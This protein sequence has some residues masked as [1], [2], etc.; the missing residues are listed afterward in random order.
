[1]NRSD[2]TLVA[3]RKTD[4]DWLGCRQTLVPGANGSAW[5]AAFE[6][7][8][9]PRLALRYLDP[10]KVLQDNGKFQGE[11]FSIAAIQCTLI[12]FLESTRLGLKYR[13]LRNGETLGPYEYCSSKAVF[14]AFLRD[15]EPFSKTF[16]ESAAGDFYVGVRC[17]LLHEAQTKNGWKIL[18]NGPDGIVADIKQKFLY[19]NNFQSALLNYVE[20]YKCDLLLNAE[21]QSAF[22][23]KFDSLCGVEP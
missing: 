6:S 11:G 4:K 20:S 23:R 17:G 18:A 13:Y 7:Y 19:R 16:T 12:E 14:V 9:R 10:I 3:G 8:F 15:R 22:L 1:M 21:L 2:E 5:A